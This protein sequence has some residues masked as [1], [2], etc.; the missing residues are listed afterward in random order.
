MKKGIHPALKPIHVVYTDGTV[1]TVPVVSNMQKTSIQLD[2][3]IK[4]HPCWNIDK[5][6]SLSETS[7]Q[8]QKFKSKFNIS[9]TGK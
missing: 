3:D 7:S 9:Y 1:L 6:S 8:L 2:I 5:R 4:S